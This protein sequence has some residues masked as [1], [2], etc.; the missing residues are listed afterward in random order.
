[1]QSHLIECENM[2]NL[3]ILVYLA[4]S[5]QEILKTRFI[6]TEK[7]FKCTNS[8]LRFAGAARSISNDKTATHARSRVN[9]NKYSG[10]FLF[11]KRIICVRFQNT[12]R[13]KKDNCVRVSVCV[14]FVR[15]A[16]ISLRTVPTCGKSRRT[17]LFLRPIQISA[18]A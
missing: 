14:N 18:E 17:G 9:A 1:M 15:A 12:G 16:L 7:K 2:H 13:I 4:Y 8:G 3:L 11:C 5:S 6:Y 10:I